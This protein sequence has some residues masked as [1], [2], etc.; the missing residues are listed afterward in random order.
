MSTF[1]VR[2]QEDIEWLNSRG[3]AQKYLR[4]VGDW[5][6]PIFCI[7]GR[8]ISISEPLSERYKNTWDDVICLANQVIEEET[9]E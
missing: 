7:T 9:N 2:N 8:D 6:V 4:R 1:P 3:T 5:M